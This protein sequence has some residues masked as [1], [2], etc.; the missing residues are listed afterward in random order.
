MPPSAAE[1]RQ[2]P[3]PKI[4]RGERGSLVTWGRPARWPFDPDRLVG[5]LMGAVFWGTVAILIG[6]AAVAAIWGV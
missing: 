6:R 3:S 4:R 2:A 5:W 1:R